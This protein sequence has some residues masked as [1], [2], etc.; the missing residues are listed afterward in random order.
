MGPGTA[1][2][3]TLHRVLQH[4]ADHGLLELVAVAAA[5]GGSDAGGGTKHDDMGEAGGG[6]A[7]VVVADAEVAKMMRQQ[8][9][10]GVA[11]GME[12]EW[13]K[14]NSPIRDLRTGRLVLCTPVEPMEPLGPSISDG[15]ASLRSSE[16]V[17]S[18]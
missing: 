6:A 15:G 13:Q 17:W 18:K 9:W 4:Y 1:A 2:V 11:D 7:S 14:L 5:G 12:P 3:P 16:L 8:R 10:T